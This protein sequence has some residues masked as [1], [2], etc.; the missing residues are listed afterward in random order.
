MSA[1]SFIALFFSSLTPDS[2]WLLF[3][4]R[5]LAGTARSCITSNVYLTEVLPR[6]IRGMFVIIESVSRGFG[7]ILTFLLGYFID[8]SMFGP[9]FGWIPL[10]R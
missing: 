6:E 8:Y 7:S 5:I 1:A 9:I 3:I 10:L 4:S 2:I